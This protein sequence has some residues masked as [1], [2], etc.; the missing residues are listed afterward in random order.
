VDDILSNPGLWK[1]ALDKFAEVTG[2]TVEL[3]DAGGIS[4]QRPAFSTPLVALLRACG[5]EPGLF[6]ECARRCLLQTSDRP[7]VVVTEA[8][9]LTVVGASLVLEGVIVGAAVAGYAFAGFF[10]AAAAQSWA[11]SAGVPFDSLWN[12]ARQQP[13]VPERRLLLHG[14][15]LQVLGDALLREN[16]RTRQYEDAVAKLEAVA[17][18]KS[19]FLAVV[20]HELRTPL[21]PILGWASI[22]KN[23]QSPAQVRKAAE[24]IERNVL[25]QTRMVDDLL[26]MNLSTRGMVKLDLGILELAACIRSTLEASAHDIERKGIRLAF[27]DAG[28][29]LFVEADSNRLQQV[30]R[31]ILSNAVKFTPAGGAIRVEISREAGNA[32]TVVTDTGVGITPEFLPFVF[33]IF[34]QQDSGAQRRHQ[35]LGIGLALVKKLAELQKG[36]VTVASTGIGGGTAVTV[37]LPLVPEPDIPDAAANAG[38]V[39]TAPLAGLSVLVIDDIEDARETLRALLLHLGAKVWVA[40]NGIEGLNMVRNANPD[41]VLCDLQMPQMDGF[42]FM[43]ELHRATLAAHPPVLALT[44]MASEADHQRTREAGFDGHLDK[45]F[46]KSALVAAVAVA[47][48]ASHATLDAPMSAHGGLR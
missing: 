32:K 20:S 47:L 17:T 24:A 30:F 35:G 11:R 25:L 26:D 28:E 2:L 7:A 14:E 36:S 15:L 9:G 8:H 34:R 40:G 13:P 43:R 16:H 3:F 6:A 38:E 45:P 22:L 18:A 27:V 42:E 41:V 4:A 23:D 39:P 48:D 5:F 44:A 21:A 12:I 19:E 37:R 46:D 31:N 33:D 29:R 10:Q 1:P